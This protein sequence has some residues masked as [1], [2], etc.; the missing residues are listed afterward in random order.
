MFDLSP[1]KD[2][3]DDKYTEVIKQCADQS[4]GWWNINMYFGR[5]R[6]KYTFWLIQYHWVGALRTPY[7]KYPR[8]QWS[9][10]ELD[11]TLFSASLACINIM[12]LNCLFNNFRY[13]TWTHYSLG[14]PQLS[15]WKLRSSMGLFDFTE[16]YFINKM[17]NND[18]NHLWFCNHYFDFAYHTAN[19]GL[20]NTITQKWPIS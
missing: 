16:Y 9:K 20:T 19:I 5:E 4:G 12:F 10:Q 3:T 2:L 1:L 18:K 14:C 15:C 11:S 17:W 6:T 8:K 7:I 13:L